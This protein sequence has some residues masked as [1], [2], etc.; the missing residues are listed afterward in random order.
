MSDARIL[1]VGDTALR[2]EGVLDFTTVGPLAVEGRRR[3]SGTGPL[4]ID[5]GAVVQANSAGLALLLEW[6]DLARQRNLTLRFRNLPDSL[7]RLAALTNLTN[8]LPVVPGRA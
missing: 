7:V 6:L 3:F 8:L 1:A 2:V 4:E 5:L